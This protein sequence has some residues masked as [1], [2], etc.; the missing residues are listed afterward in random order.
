MPVRKVI[1]TFAFIG[2]SVLTPTLSHA[3]ARPETEFK[4]FQ[5][6]P[7]MI[8]RIDGNTA[9]W[10]MVTGDYIIGSDQLTDNKTEG[11]L[12]PA[13]NPA[14]LDVRVRVGWVKGLDRLYF[15][16]EAYDDDWNMFY[17]RGDI[18]EIAVDADCSGGPYDANP[19]LDSERAY[20]DFK[21]VHAQ[22]YHIFTPAGEGRDWA[23]IPGCNPWIR[24]LPW[25]NGAYSYSFREGENGHLVCECWIT[26]FDYAPYE[27]PE[28][29]VVSK[30]AENALIGLSW[31]ILDYDGAPP[32]LDG[33][34]NLSHDFTMASNASSLCAFRLMPL[35]PSLKKPLVAQWDFTVIDRANRLVAFTDRSEGDITSW[36]WDFDD[37][38]TS[39]ERALVHRYDKP[40]EYTVVLSITGPTGE[41]KRIKVRDVVF[42]K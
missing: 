15:L 16:Y 22:N 8:P 19:Q 24:E 10:D 3:L 23:L 37:G 27:G 14:D 42:R 32:V 36:Q 40:G 41:A 5:F 35:E 28:R 17:K 20:F 26:P 18:F 7:D 11:A 6:P 25:A 21:G 13:I 4:V 9:D 38:A 33:F 31:A 30:L 12:H 29:A 39:S 2:I 34:W 1:V